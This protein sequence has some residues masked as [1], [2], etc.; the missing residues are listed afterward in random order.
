MLSLARCLTHHKNN[1]AWHDY[2]LITSSPRGSVSTATWFH[3][4]SMALELLPITTGR[5]MGG[6]AD[7]NLSDATMLSQQQIG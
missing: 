2:A 5:D 3:L 1:H 4:I 7:L 6:M